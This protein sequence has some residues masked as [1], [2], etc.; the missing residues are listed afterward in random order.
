MADFSIFASFAMMALSLLMPSAWAAEQ[1][2]LALYSDSSCLNF[3]SIFVSTTSDGS[4][5]IPVSCSESSTAGVNAEI[6]CGYFDVVSLSNCLAATTASFSIR[7][8]PVKQL[9]EV[10]GQRFLTVPASWTRTLTATLQLL[11]AMS[12]ATTSIIPCASRR[13]VQTTNDCTTTSLSTTGC[14]LT[15]GGSYVRGLCY[16]VTYSSSS[17]STVTYSSTSSSSSSQGACFSGEDTVIL[18]SGATRLFS[19]LAIGDKV[20]TTEAKGALSFSNVVALPHAVNKK[21]S[22]SVKVVTSSGKSLKATKMHLLQKCDGTLAYAGALTEGDC[23]RTVDGDEA[24][25]ALSVAKAEGIYT[26]VTTSK[27]L[28]VNGIVASPF[29]VSHGLMNSYY[30]FHRI[31]AKFAPLALASSSI[32][33]ISAVLSGVFLEAAN[34]K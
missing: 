1:Q 15:S 32:Q 34:S 24:V 3:Q 29:G 10:I 30:N 27:F 7:T 9:L 16:S 11:H 17:S 2:M 23:L 31:V 25:T 14:S 13:A 4:S 5:C 8:T 6:T 28:V 26:A 21:I 33:V 20:Q 22:S 19:E 18:E 12:R